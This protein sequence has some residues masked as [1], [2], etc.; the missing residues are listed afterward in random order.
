MAMG[1]CKFARV[2]LIAKVYILYPVSPGSDT[3]LT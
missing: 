2:P 1:V 3:V